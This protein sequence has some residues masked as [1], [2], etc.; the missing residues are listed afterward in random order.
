MAGRPPPGGRP[1]APPAGPDPKCGG[2]RQA[3]GGEPEGAITRGALWD[4]S[5]RYRYRLTRGWA[6][7][8]G[9]RVCFVLLNPSTADA[10]RDDATIRRCLAFARTWG[11]GA[12]EAVNLFA[13]AATNP[14]ALRAAADPVGP[15][16]DR[17]LQAAAAAADLVVCAWGAWGGYLHRD[18]WVLPRLRAAARGSLWC[19]GLTACG[20]PRHPLHLSRAQ[21]LMPLPRCALAPGA[22]A[23]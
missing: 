21:D 7:A 23:P 18:A 6:G 8:G 17:H 20:R 16:N 13:L 2:W 4:P 3:V 19:F 9:H 10:E 5:G 14:R 22:G 1:P 11:F 12:L 15:E